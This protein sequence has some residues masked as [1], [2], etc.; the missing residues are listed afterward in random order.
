M[1]PI[2]CRGMSVRNCH[3]SLCNNPEER[4]SQLL[5]DGS[6][7][8]RK[9]WLLCLEKRKRE[10][11]FSL[12]CRSTHCT[13][14]F[15]PWY[16]TYFTALC[17]YSIS[18][19]YKYSCK[20]DYGTDITFHGVIKHVPL[21]FVKY[22]PHLRMSQ[23]IPV[24]EWSKAWVCGCSLRET[25]GSNSASGMD[26]CTLWVLRVR[27]WSLRRDD[28]SSRGVLPT[29]VCLSVSVVMKPQ[30]GGPGPLGALASRNK[31]YQIQVLGWTME[32]LDKGETYN[33]VLSTRTFSIV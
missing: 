22:L 6:F 9:S 16:F 25:V 1:G 31:N 19:V 14:K 21:Y 4:S 3:Y 20:I 2:V 8:W 33:T 17:S 13:S 7:K 30:W 12:A 24:A 26:V 10:V 27:E 18:Q 5:C 28:H 11:Y 29:V 23:P 32:F 15:V